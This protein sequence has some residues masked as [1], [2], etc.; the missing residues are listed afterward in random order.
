MRSR[1]QPNLVSTTCFSMV[2]INCAACAIWL[3]P[4]PTSEPPRPNGCNFTSMLSSNAKQRNLIGGA[5]QEKGCATTCHRLMC[6]SVDA[7]ARQCGSRVWILSPNA[8]IRRNN[9]T[10]QHA[11]QSSNEPSENPRARST[12]AGRADDRTPQ[13]CSTNARRLLGR[14]LCCISGPSSRGSKESEE[15][16]AL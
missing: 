9:A 8:I 6:A 10:L 16:E 15:D 2:D 7:P 12:H 5:M 3:V 11:Q 14:F 4:D 1:C 13:R